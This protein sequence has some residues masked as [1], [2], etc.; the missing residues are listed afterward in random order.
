MS[1]QTECACRIIYCYEALPL[2]HSER[3]CWVDAEAYSFALCVES[4]EI[5]VRDDS[6][7]RLRAVR[8][9]LV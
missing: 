6:Q 7:G 2:L 4:I 5:D 3:L 9:E 1:V 8:L